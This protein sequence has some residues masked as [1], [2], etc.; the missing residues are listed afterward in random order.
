MRI[1]ANY[2]AIPLII[3]LTAIGGGLITSSGMAWYRSI[4]LP[5]WTPSGAIIGAI[6]TIIFVLFALA[7]I[8]AWNQEMSAR[9]RRSLTVLFAINIFLNIFWSFLFFSQHLVAAAVFEAGL[10]FFS[11]LALGLSARSVSRVAAWL[12]L[13]YGLWTAFAAYLTSA[14]WR[15]N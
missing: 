10:L 1:T 12:L 2:L 4:R 11:V 3:L 7:G 15:L 8:V 6:W 5:A 9:K 14:V 13:P